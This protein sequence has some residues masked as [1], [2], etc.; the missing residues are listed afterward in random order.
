VRRRQNLLP[1]LGSTGVPSG[2]IQ[3]HLKENSMKVAKDNVGVIKYKLNAFSINTNHVK[4][5]KIY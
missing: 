5:N 3:Q 1:P 2:N 4:G